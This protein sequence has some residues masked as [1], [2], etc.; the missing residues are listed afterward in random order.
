MSATHTTISVLK[1]I[2]PSVLAIAKNAG[3]RYR[4]QDEYSGEG[5]RGTVITMVEYKLLGEER[6][7]KSFQS[8]ADVYAE[9]LEGGNYDEYYLRHNQSL[10]GWFGVSEFSK[11][12]DAEYR[13]RAAAAAAVVAAK[14]EVERKKQ[15]ISIKEQEAEWER[16]RLAR[17]AT[18]K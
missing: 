11:K 3:L 9:S 15:I 10:T 14:Y 7:F 6:Q 8:Q 16:Q 12:R 17:L 1:N 5:M 18:K 4:K 13:E 2:A